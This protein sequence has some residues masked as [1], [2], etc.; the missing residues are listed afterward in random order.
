MPKIILTGA[1]GFIGRACLNELLGREYCVLRAGR[2]ASDDIFC[3]L[4]KPSSVL[5][6]QDVEDYEAIIHLGAS[7]D[8]RSTSLEEM[9]EPNVLST[10]IIA[11]IARQRGASLVFA[12][13]AI[14]AGLLS[15]E[16]R[17][18]SPLCPDTPYAKSKAIAEACIEASGVR[19][20]ILRI[21][22]VFGLNGPKH[23]G[24][25]RSIDGAING[26]TPMMFG[27]GSGLRN[28]I[29]SADLASIVADSVQDFKAGTYCVSGPETLSI[30][31][32]MQ[33]VSQVFL[34]NPHIE[35][36][37]GDSA[38][39]QIIMAA[40]GF[41]G[42]NSFRKCLDMIQMEALGAW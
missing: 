15:E 32:M 5:A 39:S 3:D 10:A 2:N 18:D 1:S 36:R 16:I 29:Y 19:S 40:P 23:L 34:G 13:T 17:D 37:P 38:R 4:S 28:Y 20:C 41:V 11:S 33:S 24:L 21:G 35:L 12:S 31:E 30:R 8:L 14:V 9:Y 25:N 42:Q 26:K 7:V 27:D 6:L 22:G